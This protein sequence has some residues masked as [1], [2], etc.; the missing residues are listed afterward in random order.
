M[1]KFRGDATICFGRE[2]DPLHPCVTWHSDPVAVTSSKTGGRGHK[3]DSNNPLWKAIPLVNGWNR[4]GCHA[5]Q[6]TLTRKKGFRVGQP[7]GTPSASIDLLGPL[8]RYQYVALTSWHCSGL[9]DS[10]PDGMK[11]RGLKSRGARHP[12]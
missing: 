8:Q 7:H 5:V 11:W 3:T 9:P 10:I 4:I 1:P 6:Q 2:C 12:L